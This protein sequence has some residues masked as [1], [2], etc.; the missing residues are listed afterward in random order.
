MGTDTAEKEKEKEKRMSD[1]KKKRRTNE[2]QKG[3][4]EKRERKRAP[5][6]ARASLYSSRREK[7]SRGGLGKAKGRTTRVYDEKRK[8][9]K[10]I[11]SSSRS[12]ASIEQQQQN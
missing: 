11:K 8:R 4:K 5:A 3:E 6:A 9:G 12:G 10:E 7:G 1:E 2:T